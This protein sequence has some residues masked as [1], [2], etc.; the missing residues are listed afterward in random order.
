MAH[1]WQIVAKTRDR[2]GESA[3]WHPREKAIYWVDWYGPTVYRLR[4]GDKRPAS[5]T[6]AGATILGSLVFLKD[7]R[8][9]LALDTGLKVFDQASENLEDFADPNEG[10]AGVS[11]NDSKVDRFGRYWVGTFD[12]PETEPRGVLYCVDSQGRFTLGDSGFPVC[13]G[14]AFSPQGN[15]LKIIWLGW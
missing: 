1:E 3:M 12:M 5:W 14:P 2:L 15:R 7:G 6:I 10:R 13:N 9:L 11:Y 8:L 4:A